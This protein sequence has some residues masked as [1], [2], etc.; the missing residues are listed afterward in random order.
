MGVFVRCTMVATCRPVA[1]STHCRHSVRSTSFH[2]SISLK[3][4]YKNVFVLRALCTVQYHSNTV[5]QYVPGTEDRAMCVDASM[6]VAERQTDLARA[7][8]GVPNLEKL[9]PSLR[10]SSASSVK[11]RLALF[12]SHRNACLLSTTSIVKR[13][14]VTGC[15]GRFHFRTRIT[16]A[17]WAGPLP[18]DGPVQ[19]RVECHAQIRVHPNL[20]EST[21][22]PMT[23]MPKKQE[24]GDRKRENE[25]SH[26]HCDWILYRAARRKS[27]SPDNGEFCSRLPVAGWAGEVRPA[28][29]VSTPLESFLRPPGPKPN[30]P[31]VEP[32]S[33]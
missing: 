13:P 6:G 19:R 27:T 14:P 1:N 5:P 32:H 31:N 22:S 12:P 33:G 9:F 23:G 21:P 20:A 28:H 10:S 26:L 15:P 2:T 18:L 17:D 16:G 3:H 29:G 11:C 25:A 8:S 24:A 7:R 4:I 30:E